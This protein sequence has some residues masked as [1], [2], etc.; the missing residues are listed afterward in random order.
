M[1]NKAV[2]E[3]HRHDEHAE[4]CLDMFG[5]VS[6]LEISEEKYSELIYDFNKLIHSELAAS[7]SAQ[8]DFF[9]SSGVSVLA[10]PGSDGRFEKGSRVSAVELIALLD[11]TASGKMDVIREKIKGVLTKVSPHKIAHIEWKN[12]DSLLSSFNGDRNRIQPARLGTDARPLLG[13]ESMLLAA[14]KRI[15]AEILGESGAHIKKRVDNLEAD[16]RKAMSGVNRIAGTDAV[17]FDLDGPN[18]QGV[19]FFNPNAYQLSFKIGP[20]RLVQSTLLAESVKHMRRESNQD[21]LSTLRSNIT[22][23]L[24]Q[25]SDDRMLN[26][27]NESIS[28]IK[29]HYNFF[30]RLYHRSESSYAERGVTALPLDTQEVVEIRKR[31]IDLSALMQTLKIGK[32][33][34]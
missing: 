7:F 1:Y 15:G 22:R 16:A 5:R 31:L 32:V 24:S 26:L 3:S 19:V 13:D 34:R 33:P 8:A 17:H 4:P 30:L 9:K 6:D 10:I 2:S 23:R 21:F 14:R 25:L 29:E 11:E 20:L 12:H 27:S 18:G 28:K